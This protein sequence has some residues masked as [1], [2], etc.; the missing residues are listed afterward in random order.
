MSIPPQ[1]EAPQPYAA[2][3]FAGDSPAVKRLAL[4][5]QRLA[6]HFRVALLI[7]EPGVGKQTVARELHRLSPV[8]HSPFRVLDAAHQTLTFGLAGTIYLRGLDAVPAALQGKLVRELNCMERETRLIVPS[9]SELKGMLAAGRLHSGLHAALND[10]LGSL[11]LRVPALRERLE[12]LAAIVQAVTGAALS[13][14]AVSSLTRRN[15]PNNLADLCHALANH[16]GTQTEPAQNRQPATRLNEV[17]H[18]HVLDV[19]ES[20][21]GNKLRA[22]ELLGISR[23]TLYRMLSA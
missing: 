9:R 3:V 15:W 17:M 23:S 1:D 16:T 18:R 14:E 10:R 13:G 21:S 6:P 8:R 7:G 12:D 4:Q 19:L 11:E 20:C 2:A 22:A 5:V